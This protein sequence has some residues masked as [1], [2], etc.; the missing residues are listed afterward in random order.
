M[1]SEQFAAADG[2]FMLHIWCVPL[3]PLELHQHQVGEE[4]GSGEMGQKRDAETGKCVRRSKR[5]LLA[6]N[7]SVPAIRPCLL[8]LLTGLTASCTPLIPL[9][10]SLLPHAWLG[11]HVPCS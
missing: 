3:P 7:A 11:V 4:Q 1:I 5:T 2:G 9:P 6:S 10:S 8:V